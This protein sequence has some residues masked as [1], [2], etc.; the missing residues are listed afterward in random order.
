MVN[1][2]RG[3]V[4]ALFARSALDGHDRGVISV[5]SKCRDEGMEVIYIY[6]YDPNEVA[7]A[8]AQENVDVI[9]ITSSIGQHI[10][11]ITLLKEALGQ[12]EIDI[13]VIIGG[14]VPTSDI[15]RLRDMGVKEIFGPGS[16]PSDV[17]K[18]ISQLVAKR[19]VKGAI[20]SVG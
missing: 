1:P 5:I 10:Y 18:F 20:S 2:G 3:K 15:P 13:P 8:A 9:G 6:F 16:S 12:R 7:I 19:D 14:V 17:V 4:R 11:V